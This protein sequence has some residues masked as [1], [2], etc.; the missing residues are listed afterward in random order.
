MGGKQKNAHLPRSRAER[1]IASTFFKVTLG[2]VALGAFSGNVLAYPDYWYVKDYEWIGD[3][4]GKYEDVHALC[5]E[6]GVKVA[7][8]HPDTAWGEGYYGQSDTGWPICGVLS[9]NRAAWAAMGLVHGGCGKDYLPIPGAPDKFPSGSQCASVVD[10]YRDPKVCKPKLGNPILPFTGE[11]METVDLG[12]GLAGRNLVLTFNSGRGPWA[13]QPEEKFPMLGAFGPLWFSNWHV[14]AQVPNYRSVSFL[15]PDGTQT[16]IEF[17]NGLNMR[18]GEKVKGGK[19]DNDTLEF[20]TGSPYYGYVYR[21]QAERTLTTYRSIGGNRTNVD[22]MYSSAGGALIY[23]Y[24]TSSPSSGYPSAVSDLF[25]RRVSFTYKTLPSGGY[26]VA[27]VQD[28]AGQNYLFDHDQY[29]NLIRITWPEGSK[30]TFVYD[31]PHAGQ[32]SALTGVIDELGTRYSTFAYDKDGFAISTEHVGGV[33]RYEVTS[34]GRPTRVTTQSYDPVA[35]VITRYHSWT[36]SGEPVI[37]T[38]PSGAVETFKA[39]DLSLG[40]PRPTGREQPAGSGCS[41]SSSSE[42]YDVN[43][44]TASADDFDQLRTCFVNDLDRNLQVVRVEGLTTS[45]A[46]SS[47]TGAG[48]ALPTGSRKISTQWHPEWRLQTRVAKPQKLTT[49]VYHGQPDPLNGGSLASC[50][51]GSSGPLPGGKPIAVLCKQVEQATTDADG[52]LAFNAAVQPGTPAR[53]RRWTYNASGQILMET[54]PLNRTKTYAYY[55]DTAF[56]GTDAGA[57]GHTIGDVRSITNAA[58]H[59]TQFTQ[60]DKLGRIRQ[61]VEPTG[62]VTDFTYAPRGWLSTITTSASGTTPRTTSYEYDAVGQQKRIALPDGTELTYSYDA[63]HR[64]VG[65]KDTRGNEITYFLDG[66]GNRIGEEIRD[67]SGVLRQSISR[68]FDIL[69]RVQQ[70]TGAPR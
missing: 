57:T 18:S 13:R 44:N 53:I 10:V 54:D 27:T 23:T 40:F 25:G 29:G 36:A 52:A 16:S 42:T 26:A 48:A 43:G 58:G 9:L 63:A 6:F 47:V 14:T 21:D 46:C 34:A 35:K 11:K 30:R 32:A 33:H 1:W 3:F 60:Y 67:P 64:L 50:I 68:S 22:R 41:A 59:V 37:V 49:F 45:V 51:V 5:R 31:S 69:G 20:Y 55:T 62:V 24:D 39:P 7:E 28:P 65:V 19:D 2:A 56:S 66:A 4:P 38:K 15:R 8:K 61:R 17:P 12:F 70:V